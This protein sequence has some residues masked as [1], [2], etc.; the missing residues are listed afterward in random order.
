MPNAHKQAGISTAS[1]C[2]LLARRRCVQA[3]TCEGCPAE[4]LVP[5]HAP[6]PVV[7]ASCPIPPPQA[8]Y[9]LI[10]YTDMSAEVREEVL[11][12]CITACEKYG[13]DMERCT[14]VG[15]ACVHALRD[16][17]LSL[18]PVQRSCAPGLTDALLPSLLLT[19]LPPPSTHA[20]ARLHNH[21]RQQI[22]EQMDRKFGSPWHV[23]VGRAFAYEI[24]YELRNM[25]Y[26]FVGGT[27]G[28][29]LWKM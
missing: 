27:T 17:C 23:I 28:V 29:L 14:Q 19:E 10:K 24:T 3:G 21:T 12:I 9:P 6:H 2:G 25:L 8:K 20:R 7:R 18:A 15:G 13:N 5:L 4:R 11:D 16:A 26:L 22:K 1:A